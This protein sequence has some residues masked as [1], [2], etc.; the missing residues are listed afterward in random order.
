MRDK[1]TPKDVCGEAT[2]YG[3]LGGLINGGA[4]MLGGLYTA[5]DWTRKSASKQATAV[6]FKIC[7]TFSGTLLDFKMS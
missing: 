6:L 1:R 5:C 7:F 4:Y 2:L 3:V